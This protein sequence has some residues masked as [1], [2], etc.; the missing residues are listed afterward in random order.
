MLDLRF[1]RVTNKFSSFLPIILKR[2]QDMRV[3]FLSSLLIKF[4]KTKQNSQR[5][6]IFHQE[7]T[8]YNVLGVKLCHDR[9]LLD[10]EQVNIEDGFDWRPLLHRNAVLLK[11]KWSP[12]HFSFTRSQFWVRVNHVIKN[13][14]V[15]PRSD[16]LASLLWT[17]H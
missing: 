12:N 17:P 13:K 2:Y 10:L 4:W 6:K 3:A 7:D 5:I 16:P 8:C 15:A 14:G 1:Y 9:R 11:S